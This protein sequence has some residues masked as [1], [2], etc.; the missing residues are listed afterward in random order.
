M[1]RTGTVISNA[2][3]INS[4][5]EHTINLMLSLARQTEIMLPFWTA[6]YNQKETNV[7]L[8]EKIFS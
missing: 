3:G 6:V 1:K 5:I 2:D 8:A 4:I 7:E